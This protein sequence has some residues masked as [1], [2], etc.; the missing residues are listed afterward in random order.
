MPLSC[1]LNTLQAR[2]PVSQATKKSSIAQWAP[3]GHALFCTACPSWFSRIS[4]PA[5]YQCNQVSADHDSGLATSIDQLHHAA[6]PPLYASYEY[7]HFVW[8]AST[9]VHSPSWV[10]TLSWH[11]TWSMRRAG[12]RWHCGGWKCGRWSKRDSPCQRCSQGNW[13][14]QKIYFRTS[15]SQRANKRDLPTDFQLGPKISV[16]VLQN[17]KTIV[18]TSGSKQLKRLQSFPVVDLR[19]WSRASHFWTRSAPTMLRS[20]IFQLLKHQ[21]LIDGGITNRDSA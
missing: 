13:R 4:H 1:D 11:Y 19:N 8:F 10:W 6:S 2:L 12:V 17:S 3:G 20:T 14:S 16:E 18:W 15:L 5:V 21:E 7:L 9:V